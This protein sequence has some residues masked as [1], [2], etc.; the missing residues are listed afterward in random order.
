ML[1]QQDSNPQPIASQ[2]NTQPFGPTDQMI[3]LCYKNLS[4][5]FIYCV[6]LLC[7]TSILSQ[8]TLC[9]RLNSKE[10]IA[11]SRPNIWNL[12]DYIC[13]WTHNQLVCKLSLNHLVIWPNDWTV[14]WE[15][16]CMV[17][18]LWVFI[19]TYRFRVNIHSVNA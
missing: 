19:V 15:I 16:I 5:W 3:K 13:I 9:N 11:Q 8:S 14:S 12:S 17:G 10:H 2:M 4:V 6:L 18:W 1:L 7:Q